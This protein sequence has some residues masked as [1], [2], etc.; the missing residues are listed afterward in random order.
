[1]ARRILQKILLGV[2]SRSFTGWAKLLREAKQ[3]AKLGALRAEVEDVEKLRLTAEQQDELKKEKMARRLLGNKLLKTTAT[4][5]GAWRSDTLEMR[6]AKVVERLEELAMQQELAADEHKERMAKKIGMKIRMAA[7]QRC[8]TAWRDDVREE[9]R[10]R[11]GEQMEQAQAELMGGRI[12]EEERKA[13]EGRTRQRRKTSELEISHGAAQSAAAAAAAKANEVKERMSRFMIRMTGRQQ[14]HQIFIGW[15]N[16]VAFVRE[17]AKRQRELQ[18]NMARIGGVEGELERLTRQRKSMMGEFEDVLGEA[19]MELEEERRRS[20]SAEEIAEEELQSSMAQLG[21][22][23][24][25]EL[26]R[27]K[28]SYNRR[29]RS[30][31]VEYEDAL[32]AAEVLTERVAE[33]TERVAELELEISAMRDISAARDAA[34]Q[35][36]SSA[37]Q[38]AMDVLSGKLQASDMHK[39][40]LATRSQQKRFLTRVLL[41]WRRATRHD[42]LAREIDT[43]KAQQ[44]ALKERRALEKCLTTG[45]RRAF[46]GWKALREQALLER[47]AEQQQAEKVAQEEESAAAVGEVEGELERLRK[48]RRSMMIEY[49]EALE[50]ADT[51]NAKAGMLGAK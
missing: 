39:D 31:M 28:D 22:T 49:E 21:G 5:F 38:T 15:R 25:E 44:E 48:M 29:R 42:K 40:R 35:D 32:G 7:V 37:M 18:E 16:A 46:F 4:I 43:T 17:K 26:E 45:S 10:R 27:L 50:E 12:A 33:L 1:M 47:R 30:M 36:G 24:E 8:L 19:E 14:L 34:A 11:L 41:E 6:Q 20:L 3:E 51:L 9:K 23:H 2:V 13:E